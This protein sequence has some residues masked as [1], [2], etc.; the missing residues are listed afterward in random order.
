MG[1]AT[2]R[3]NAATR[4]RAAAG[5]A[6]SLVASLALFFVIAIAS[7]STLTL[8]MTLAPRS[9]SAMESQGVTP[10]GST[11]AI[12]AASDTLHR[13]HGPAIAFVVALHFPLFLLFYWLGRKGRHL[14][15]AAVL[16]AGLLAC[17]IVVSSGITLL[18]VL[19]AVP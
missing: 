14:P 4:R 19:P 18:L 2:G 5:S 9:R 7:F 10:P 12:I 11:R 1:R 3:K 8:V 6:A 16:A 15:T 17:E 13:Y